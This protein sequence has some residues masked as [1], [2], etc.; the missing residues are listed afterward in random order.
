MENLDPEHFAHSLTL[1]HLWKHIFVNA[2]S[3]GMTSKSACDLPFNKPGR[4]S[5][6]AGNEF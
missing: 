6:S 5:G 2:T 1:K 3:Q 4:S